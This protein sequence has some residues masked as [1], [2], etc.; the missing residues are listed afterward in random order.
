MRVDFWHD[1]HR[2]ERLSLQCDI[3]NAELF[4]PAELGERLGWLLLDDLSVRSIDNSSTKSH[5]RDPFAGGFFVY[6][7]TT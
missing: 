4:D 2:W 5:R 1:A 7:A 3:G 6:G